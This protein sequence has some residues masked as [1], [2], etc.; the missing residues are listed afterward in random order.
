MRTGWTIYI[1][2][3]KFLPCIFLI[4]VLWIFSPNIKL[5]VLFLLYK[6]Y[7]LQI[8]VYANCKRKMQT[9]KNNCTNNPYKHLEKY[10]STH[11]WWMY[12][13]SCY[14]SLLNVKS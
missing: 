10:W 9:A 5:V 3:E 14:K 2:D 1:S 11:F 6:M 13:I 12:I 4:L 8:R 7:W